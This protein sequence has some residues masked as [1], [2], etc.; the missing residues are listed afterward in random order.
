MNNSIS[1]TGVAHQT[2]FIKYDY[3]GNQIS[4]SINGKVMV[5]ATQMAKPFGKLAKDWLKTKQAKEFL[6]VLLESKRTKILLN[7]YQEVN[8]ELSKVRNLTLADL[9]IVKSGGSNPGTWFHED[10]ALEFARWLSPAFA[11][12]CNDRIKE[13]MKY[14]ITATP[15]TIED[16]IAQPENAVKLLSALQAERKR[17][18]VLSDQ[19]KVSESERSRLI[20]LHRKDDS[21]IAKLEKRIALLEKQQTQEPLP[22]KTTVLSNE[23]FR[24]M[25]T[26]AADLGRQKFIRQ[27]PKWF[28]APKP[29]YFTIAGYA[30]YHGLSVNISTASRLGIQATKI[31]YERGYFVDTTPDS[32]FGYVNMYP[33]EVLDEVFLHEF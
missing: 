5:N 27:N 1:Q 9:V 18:T 14:G 29:E 8:T 19:F 2:S 20:N 26:V 28:P 10:V 3:Q 12:W 16:I 6:E 11:I 23:Q 32:R 30:R 13:L 17:T 24:E 33:K 21:T 31:C 4:F 15:Q 22:S 7:D 25:M